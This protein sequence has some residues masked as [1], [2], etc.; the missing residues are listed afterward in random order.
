MNADESNSRIITH[1]SVD[2]YFAELDL[3]SYLL[4]EEST[5][6]VPLCDAKRIAVLPEQKVEEFFLAG[7]NDELTALRL[8]ALLAERVSEDQIAVCASCDIVNEIISRNKI[9]LGLALPMRHM[10]YYAW[11]PADAATTTSHV[12]DMKMVFRRAYVHRFEKEILPA[13]LKIGFGSEITYS[14]NGVLTNGSLHSVDFHVSNERIGFDN[15]HGVA[16]RPH[17]FLGLVTRVLF[18]PDTVH[19]MY[20]ESY[21]LITKALI[22]T[23]VPEF[24]TT[25]KYQLK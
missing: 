15:I 23:R 19:S 3:P 25:P 1:P 9:D 24:E 16:A 20:V 21:R 5:A 4:P 13:D 12:A 2:R 6:F 8:F 7:V 22:T 17:G 14:E 10:A 18:I 11:L